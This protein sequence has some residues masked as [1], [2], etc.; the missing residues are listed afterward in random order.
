MVYGTNITQV[1]GTVVLPRLPRLRSKRF[2]PYRDI[3]VW[4]GV[5]GKGC[6]P[7]LARAG[8][9]VK[10]NKHATAWYQWSPSRKVVFPKMVVK[11]GD[12][13]RMGVDLYNS[14]NGNVWLHN[15]SRSTKIR[16]HFAKQ[17]VPLC[18]LNAAWIMEALND[19]SGYQ[20]LASFERIMFRHCRLCRQDGEELRLDSARIVN[21]K[22]SGLVETDCWV[23]K[24]DVVCRDARQDK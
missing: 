23:D 18:Q 17:Q 13:V 20:G 21:L 10:S 14:T 19:K 11:P 4:V 9:T 12:W 16:H 5:D 22:R 8:V 2:S 24:D 7:A 3:S 6:H 15:I 1:A